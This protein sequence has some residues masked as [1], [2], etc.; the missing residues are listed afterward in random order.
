M[1]RLAGLSSRRALA[2]FW[3][4]VYRLGIAW[5]SLVLGECIAKL[6]KYRAAV[7]QVTKVVLESS[8]SSDDLALYPE[9]RH[10]VGNALLSL[11]NDL[12]DRSP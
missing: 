7:G 5:R 4:G 3:V 10:A 6:R 2:V 8:K 11:G 1:C 12:E 9:G